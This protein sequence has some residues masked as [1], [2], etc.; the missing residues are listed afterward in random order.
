MRNSERHWISAD[1][2]HTNETLRRSLK[3]W[4]R[5][6]ISD[7]GFHSFRFDFVKVPYSEL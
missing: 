2:D 1:L 6:L 4:M 3:D 5:W 7:I